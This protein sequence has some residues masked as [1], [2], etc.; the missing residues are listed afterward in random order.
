MNNIKIF[1]IK[2]DCEKKN[3]LNNFFNL[4]KNL[5]KNFILLIIIIFLF[6]LLKNNNFYQ[7]KKDIKIYKKYIASCRKYKNFNHETKINQN[8]YL[9]IIIPAYNMENYIERALL[10][11]LNQKFKDLEIIII[12]DY[13]NDNTKFIIKNFSFLFNNIK[14]IEHKENLGI[15][16]SRI[17]GV[18]YSKGKYILYL[19]SDDAILNPL[20][21]KKIYNFNINY[22]LDII[23]FIVF[24][25]EEGKDSIYLPEDDSL[26]HYHNFNE[27]NISTKSI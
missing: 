1:N 20:L 8:P 15:Y 14:I 3:Y 9:S 16:A 24:Y 17:D 23:E 13:S 7:L 25:E 27:N 26:N 12:H 2:V 22:N 11:I 21:F 4:I 5:I 18:L 6:I 19:D 10:S